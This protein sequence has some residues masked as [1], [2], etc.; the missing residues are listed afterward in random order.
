MKFERILYFAM[1]LAVAVACKGIEEIE[2]AGK[3]SVTAEIEQTRVSYTD[4]DSGLKQSWESGD[5]LKGWFEEPSSIFHNIKFTVSEI[6]DGI[7]T[8]TTTS[9]PLPSQGTAVHLVYAPGSGDDVSFV[10]MTNQGTT[11]KAPALMSSTATV[12]ENGLSFTF[13][14]DCAIIEITGMKGLTAGK[15]INKISVTDL[16]LLGSYSMVNNTFNLTPRNEVQTLDYYGSWTVDENGSIGDR[17]L[18]TAIP[19]GTA[20]KINVTATATDGSTYT[21]SLGEKTLAAGKCYRLAGK[22]LSSAARIDDKCFATLSE[23]FTYSNTLSAD[24]EIVLLG[25]SEISDNRALYIESGKKVTLDLNGCTIRFGKDS[26]IS[27]KSGNTLTVKDSGTDGAIVSEASYSPLKNKGTLTIEGGAFS[28]GDQP[29][30][31]NE[32]DG[33]VTISGG[34][35]TGT[36]AV[37][38]FGHLTIDGGEFHSNGSQSVIRNC[39]CD[40]TIN[41]GVFYAGEE[42]ILSQVE[43]TGETATATVNGGYFYCGA[44]QSPIAASCEGTVQVRAGYFASTKDLSSY[45]MGICEITELGSPIVK[46]GKTYGYKVWYKADECTATLNGTGYH[47]LAEAVSVSNSLTEDHTIFLAKSSYPADAVTFSNTSAA[48]TLDLKGKI[49]ESQIIVNNGASLTIKDVTGETAGAVYSTNPTLVVN[50]G[51]T[52]TIDGGTYGRNSEDYSATTISNY[53][54]LNIIYGEFLTTGKNILCYESSVTDI[55]TGRFISNS[56][57][58]IQADGGVV[59]IAGGDFRAYST[60]L[61][62]NGATCGI[63]GGTFY[64][65]SAALHTGQNSGVTISGGTFLSKILHT[66]VVEGGKTTITGGRFEAI[67]PNDESETSPYLEE[68]EQYRRPAVQLKGGEAVLSGGTFYS[69]YGPAVSLSDGTL[70]VS[71][72]SFLHSNTGTVIL[73]NILSNNA[74]PVISITG[75]YLYTPYNKGFLKTTSDAT[76]TLTGGYTNDGRYYIGETEHT[77]TGLDSPIQKSEKTF[78]YSIP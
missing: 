45:V 31:D 59:T 33:N 77:V 27:I 28:C 54:T 22:E 63:T 12:T 72:D 66:V 21:L 16:C 47:T 46:D 44:T 13:R 32:D 71:G 26:H 6:N 73:A 15:V 69:Q 55:T 58:C 18:I 74:T 51:G 70:T 8:L 7:A 20:S 61:T 67:N 60:A 17:I 9:Q 29:A 36:N 41:G 14:N 5:E 65:E 11:V 24:H 40:A 57:D 49:L 37:H 50:A 43:D 3:F 10:G 2:T 4:T 76:L 64:G 19:N 39:N 53:G 1:A 75:G 48:V 42:Y 78:G 56:G 34:V 25:D 38:N 23:A 35:F 68:S 30:V 52:L 62:I